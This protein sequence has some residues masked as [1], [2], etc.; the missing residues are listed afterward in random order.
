MS[1]KFQPPTSSITGNWDGLRFKVALH[2]I[3]G[4][5]VSAGLFQQEP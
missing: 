1:K 2:R 5:T 4:I 3:S